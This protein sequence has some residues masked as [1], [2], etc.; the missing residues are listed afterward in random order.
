MKVLGLLPYSLLFI[1]VSLTIRNSEF[2]PASLL[3]AQLPAECLSSVR[4][5]LSS[6]QKEITNMWFVQECESPFGTVLGEDFA[7]IHLSRSVSVQS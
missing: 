4:M 7:G 2:F 6:P 3:E 5:R 1:A